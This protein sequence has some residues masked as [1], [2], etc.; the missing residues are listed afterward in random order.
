M[1]MKRKLAIL[2]Y[3]AAVF[4]LGVP[5][6]WRTTSIFRAPLPLAAMLSAQQTPLS[7]P[8]LRC[9][10][11][12]AS[13][14]LAAAVSAL[15]RADGVAVSAL[16]APRANVSASVATAA[17][18]DA[19]LR[20]FAA[21]ETAAPGRYAVFLLPAAKLPRP[22][23]GQWR[24]GWAAADAAADDVAAVC[25]TLTQAASDEDLSVA[26]VRGGADAYRLALSLV[27]EDP[28]AV[29]VAWRLGDLCAR[30]LR[31]MLAR[32]APFVRFAR[33]DGEVVNYAEVS[34]SGPLTQ[35]LAQGEWGSELQAS[36]LPAV[37]LAVLVPS[38]RRP[39]LHVGETD[40]FLVPRWGGLAIHSVEEEENSNGTASTALVE[41]TP[42]NAAHDMAL[43]VAHLRRLV[44]L[45]AIKNHSAAE[46]AVS[47]LYAGSGGVLE[48]EVDALVRR[49]AQDCANEAAESLAALATLLEGAR[50]MRV[51][52]EA[53]ER[54]HGALAALAEASAA[55]ERGDAEAQLGAARRALR[56][57]DAA[58]F[59]EHALAIM[60]FPDEHK[61][62]IY[63]PLFLPV[64]VQLL[65]ATFRELR[66]RRSKTKENKAKAD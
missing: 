18:V 8:P 9:T 39:P 58:F 34:R 60:A 24:H 3:F 55:Q 51:V 12:G 11:F 64:G 61:Y 2:L 7:P 38:P 5:M 1:K 13:P 23:T 26:A 65:S 66:H 46:A 63:V 54:V 21:A 57:A 31:P 56:L 36:L 25:R 22:F 43:L 30:Y 20:P 33:C 17:A 50:Y 28:A 49:H 40:A 16:P 52:P 47:V 45:P 29:R 53:A 14:A 42:E 59:D 37:R 44:G 35:L 27:N 32:L 10:L 62:A 48:W 6:W 4:A 41:L 19:A 15:L